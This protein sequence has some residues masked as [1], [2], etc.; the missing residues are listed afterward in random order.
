MADQLGRSINTASLF[1]AWCTDRVKT[2]R[3]DEA[4]HKCSDTMRIKASVRQRQAS[5]CVRFKK[6][7]KCCGEMAEWLKAHAWKACIP[8]GIQGSNPCLSAI[9]CPQPSK[10]IQ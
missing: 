8:Q 3:G 1:N 10:K 2:V 5:N 7:H 6:A 4:N 9:K